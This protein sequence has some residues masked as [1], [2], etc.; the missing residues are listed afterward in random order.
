MEKLTSSHKFIDDQNVLYKA[1][2]GGG[3]VGFQNLKTGETTYFGRASMTFS[4]KF[5]ERIGKYVFGVKNF[6]AVG[7]S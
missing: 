4:L 6:R 2:I 5:V 7:Q 3:F 1:V